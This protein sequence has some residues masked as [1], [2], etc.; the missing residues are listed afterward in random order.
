MRWEGPGDPLYYGRSVHIPRQ[1]IQLMQPPSDIAPCSPM[2]WYA[3]DAVPGPW[4]WLQP[5]VSVPRE[6]MAA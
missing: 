6:R 3:N 5:G 2:I 4:T 1:M